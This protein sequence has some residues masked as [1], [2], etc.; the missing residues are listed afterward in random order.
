MTVIRGS[1]T[2]PR[3]AAASSA[4][5]WF[6]IDVE[7]V[8]R[9]AGEELEDRGVVVSREYKFMCSSLGQELIEA[10]VVDGDGEESLAGENGPG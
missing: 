9:W 2:V 3:R 5:G 10:V 1:G 6:N 7:D 8:A 4:S